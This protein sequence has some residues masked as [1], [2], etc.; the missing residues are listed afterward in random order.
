MTNV[1]VRIYVDVGTKYDLKNETPHRQNMI[2]KYIYICN[3]KDLKGKWICLPFGSKNARYTPLHDRVLM[4]RDGSRSSTWDFN[5][6]HRKPC[7]F[8]IVYVTF[9]EPS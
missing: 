2:Q 3:C 1:H 4:L 7:S 8:R 5:V 6:L 9:L